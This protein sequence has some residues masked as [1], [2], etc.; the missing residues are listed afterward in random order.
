MI[1]LKTAFSNEE[2]NMRVS[3]ILLRNDLRTY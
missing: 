1:Y 3:L 2:K